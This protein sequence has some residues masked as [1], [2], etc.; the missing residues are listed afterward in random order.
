MIMI[1]FNDKFVVIFLEEILMS[2]N[3]ALLYVIQNTV[4]RFYI[5]KIVL[6]NV[7]FVQAMSRAGPVPFKLGLVL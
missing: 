2:I 4:L 7:N 3:K 1:N 5:K 6:K